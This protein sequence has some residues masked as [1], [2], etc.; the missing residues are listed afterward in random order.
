MLP[1]LFVQNNYV[2]AVR[3]SDGAIVNTTTAA[4]KAGDIL[5]IYG[6]GFGPTTPSV[7]PRLVFSAADPTAN[8]VTVKIG[9]VSATVL[10][11]GVTAAGLYQI[12]VTVPS[13]LTAGDNSFVASV[14]GYTTQSTALLRVA[15]S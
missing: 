13:G 4:V 10:W 6:T 11:A 1:G 2:L 3:V 8:T 15:V 5:E 9:G 7:T 12:N 14:G